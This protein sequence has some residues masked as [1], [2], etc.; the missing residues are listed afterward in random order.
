MGGGGG[1]ELTAQYLG[2][3]RGAIYPVP[4]TPEELNPQIAGL[5]ATFAF[6]TACRP[7]EGLAAKLSMGIGGINAFV[8]SRPL[9][10]S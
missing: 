7:P 9:P 3:A 1:W 5:D 6:D 8:L 2:Y 10:P 4:L